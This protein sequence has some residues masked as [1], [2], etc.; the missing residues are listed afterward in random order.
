MQYSM[1]NKLKLPEGTDNVRRQDF[2]D[3]FNII[4][5]GLT[6]FYVATLES[7]NTYKITTGNSLTAL[8]NGYSIKVAIPSDSSGAVNVKVDSVTVPVK[9]PNGSAVTNFKKNAVYSLVYY[10]SVF[11]LTSGSGGDDVSFSASDLLTGKTANDSNGEVVTGT[12]PNKGAVTQSLSANGTINLGS[13][14][15]DSIK[16]T[17]SLATRGATVWRPSSKAQSIPSGTYLTGTQTIE[18]DVNL[19]PQNIRAGTSIFGVGGALT[20]ESLGGYTKTSIQNK[21]IVTRYK[22]VKRGEKALNLGGTSNNMYEVLQRY[23]YYVRDSGDKVCDVFYIDRNFN[24]LIFCKSKGTCSTSQNKDYYEYLQFVNLSEFKTTDNTRTYL[25]LDQVGDGKKYSS[26]PKT[27]NTKYGKLIINEIR[28]N[29]SSGHSWCETST[30]RLQTKAMTY[31][32]L[33]LDH[34]GYL[35]NYSSS[36]DM[37]TTIVNKYE[38]RK[39]VQYRTEYQIIPEVV[40]KNGNVIS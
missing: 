33:T 19:A 40:D 6:K 34:Y 28:G 9:K 26:I 36:S 27:G 12:M 32:L 16:I 8:N 17:Q 14:H 31:D 23:R 4:D 11:T 37:F 39:N 18:G 22:V 1:N 5:N 20:V 38:N 13:G 15:Y 2:V 30:I 7:I 29:S 25:P 35:F 21:G 24:N 3:N 10:N